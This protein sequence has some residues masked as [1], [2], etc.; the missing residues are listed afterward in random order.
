MKETIAAKLGY[1]MQNNAKNDHILRK[2]G[3]LREVWANWAGNFGSVHQK[4][5]YLLAFIWFLVHGK[6]VL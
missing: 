1:K 3:L 5:L 4:M 6:Y 2:I